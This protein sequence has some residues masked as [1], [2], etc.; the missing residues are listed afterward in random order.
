MVKRKR[1]KPVCGIYEIRCVRSGKVYVGQSVHIHTRWEQHK[2]K[3]RER[4]HT[5]PLLQLEVNKYGLRSL[6]FRVVERCNRRQLNRRED[7]WIHRLN[8][9]YNCQWSD[10]S[11][12]VRRDGRIQPKGAIAIS[13]KRSPSLIP[14]V[15]LE[16]F[17]QVCGW[18]VGIL[19]IK[20]AI[21]P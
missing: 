1:V 21:A 5:N 16:G 3:L 12:L 18:V 10:G 8:A 2:D 6:R 14:P 17:W 15:A 19:I 9:A 11:K 20:W 13:S 4:S 7:Y